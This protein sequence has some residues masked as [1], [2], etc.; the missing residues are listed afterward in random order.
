MNSLVII[1]TAGIVGNIATLPGQT[2]GISPFT[3]F[4]LEVLPLSRSQL[5]MAYLVGTTLSAITMPTVGGWYDRYGS[6]RLGVTASFALGVSVI[7]ISY[8]D[9]GTDLLSLYLTS[10]PP[11][12]LA[13]VVMSAGFF[14]V[15]FFGQGMLNMVSRNMVMKWFD[16]KRGMAN[17]IMGPLSALGFA[18]SPRLFNGMIELLGWRTAWQAMGFTLVGFVGL[19]TFF[20]FKDPT[21]Q[22]LSKYREKSREKRTFAWMRDAP[23]PMRP[24]EDYTLAQARRTYSFWMFNLVNGFSSLVATGFTFHVVSI[25]SSAGMDRGIALAVFLPATSIAVAVQAMGSIV[26]DYIRLRCFAVIQMAGIATLSTASLFLAPGLPYWLLV[27]GLGLN[28]AMMS[29]NGAIVWPRFFGLS[30][31]GSISGESFVWTVAGS[32]LG[33]YA[34]SLSLSMWGS[35]DGAVTTFAVI[36][37]ILMVMSVFAYNPNGSQISK[38]L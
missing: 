38:D 29:I 4:L 24:P 7:A 11:A 13:T 5:S 36:A 1:L 30:H 25:F 3:D 17:S 10:I 33:P 26:S 2:N 23:E 35:Y 9:L 32:A 15:R 27:L 31:L 14:L 37:L 34:Y 16:H 12:I 22:D 20:T 21:Q 28:T 18:Y 6:R 19:F 8:A